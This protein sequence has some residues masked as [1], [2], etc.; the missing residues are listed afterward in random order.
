MT[1]FSWGARSG[2]LTERTDPTLKNEGWGTRKIVSVER[3]E[4]QLEGGATKTQIPRPALTRE[5]TGFCA[6]R[7]SG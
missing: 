7:A 1:T 5:D 2:L 4:G 3:A 6:K